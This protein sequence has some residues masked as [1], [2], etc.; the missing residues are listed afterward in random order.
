MPN[1]ENIRN[2]SAPNPSAPAP[3]YAARRLA[4]FALALAL[5]ASGCA[6][7]GAATC[8]PGTTF[9]APDGCNSCKCPKNGNP[10]DAPC[11]EIG[12]AKTC[13]TNSQCAESEYCRFSVFGVCPGNSGDYLGACEKR[14]E[15]CIQGGT[16]ACGCGG[17]TALNECLLRQQ[18][19]NPAP[20]TN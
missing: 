6:K 2:N 1:T 8:Q 20:C 14:P 15:I 4:G 11:T 17:A 5:A 18:G 7:P 10:N 16:G 9:A 13:T 12:C 19:I 3:K